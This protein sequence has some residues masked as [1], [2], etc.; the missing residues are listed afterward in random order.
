MTSLRRLWCAL[1]AWFVLSASALAQHPPGPDETSRLRD[2]VAAQQQQL[3]AQRRQLEELRALV[4]Q[5]G[6]VLEAL[7]ASQPSAPQLSGAQ[8]PTGGAASAAIAEP[9]NGTSSTPATPA[10]S[11][12]GLT[13][14]AAAPQASAA[15]PTAGA[16]T[17]T[18][19]AARETPSAGGFDLGAVRVRPGGYFAVTGIYRSTNSGGNVGTNF[20]T[21]PYEDRV[22]G[23]VSEARLT[24][25]A[26]RLSLRLD[27]P[28][29]GLVPRMAGYFEM[30]FAGATPGTVAVTSSGVGPRLRHVFG[31]VTLTETTSLAIGQA[32]TLMTPA[33]DQ[34]SIWPSD[35]EISQAVDSNFVAGLVW[36][37]LPQVRVTWR[38]S[39]RFNWAVSAENPEQQVGGRVTW[40]A[41]CGGDLNA[42][43]NSGS[44]EL[45]VPNLVP[46][47]VT[48]VA[49]NAGSRIH[50]DV[51]GVLRVFR[52]TLSPYDR[53]DRQVGGGVSAN[54]AVDLGRTRVLLQGAWGSGMGRYIG[55]L[56]PDVIV[57][58]DGSISPIRS[59]SWVTGLE[60]GASPRVSLSGYFSGAY[61]DQAVALDADGAYMGYGYAGAP[62]TH[63]R[64]IRQ[65]TGIVNWQ[66][67]R[68]PDRGS[69]HL[70]AQASWL[71]RSPWSRGS[72]P[73]S[74]DAFLFLTQVRY[75]LP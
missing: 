46:D 54:T 55:G 68:T 52:H 25:Q 18:P 69:V 33:R 22:E 11:R 58:A 44:E 49:F 35:Y 24:A 40:P 66:M 60:Y 56:V 71:T 1:P 73:D 57:R 64:V 8:G 30:D 63:N 47:F 39:P 53:G 3:D 50:A 20:A 59:G 2:M 48:R 19:A 14:S 67:I 26:T 61:A 65:A 31:D 72:G 17:S 51:G 62:N 43:Y 6:R 27:G 4:L 7:R 74:A 29:R 41:C 5:Q 23:N 38:P 36:G 15:P 42:Q 34:L 37:R 28:R 13:A 75:N 32:F 45:K 9:P 70:N 10:D 16:A 12:A 21:T